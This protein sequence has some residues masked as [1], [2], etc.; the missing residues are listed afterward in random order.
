MRLV[1]ILSLLSPHLIFGFIP[2]KNESCSTTS[3]E[4]YSNDSIVGLIL[5]RGG[6]RGIPLKNLAKLDDQQTLLSRALQTILSV[7]GFHSVWVSTE[8]DRIAQAVEREFP[9]SLVKVHQRPM[10][11]ALDNTSSAESV[12]E[13]LDQHP[14]VQNVALVQC[15]SPFLKV[16]YLEEALLRFQNLQ[17]D[18]LF[19]VMR[20]FK[21]RWRRSENGKVRALNFDPE[22]RP[23]RQDWD[24]ELVETGMFYF[25]RKEL[26][27]EDRFQNENCEVV[28]I[29]EKDSLEI[30]TLYDLELARMIIRSRVE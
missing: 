16:G 19:S 10:E 22:K 15:T 13:F 1:W 26:I 14:W 6:S 11:V 25:A 7:D 5:A 18:C 4:S 17:V 2:G 29:D 3:T 12:R 23:R 20:S 8:D 30:D 24:G 21:L 9:D 28:V 27:L